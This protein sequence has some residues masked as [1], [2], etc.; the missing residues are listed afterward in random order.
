MRPVG[1]SVVRSV[2]PTG[3]TIGCSLSVHIPHRFCSLER[4]RRSRYAPPYGILFDAQ[5]Q[6]FVSYAQ[7]RLRYCVQSQST[8]WRERDRVKMGVAPTYHLSVGRSVGPSVGR[9]KQYRDIMSSNLADEHF[10]LSDPALRRRDGQCG[11][12]KRS[13]R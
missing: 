4:L 9:V 2:W 1:R 10:V 5:R 6:Q 13:P 7:C 3:D 12:W 11:Q 8:E